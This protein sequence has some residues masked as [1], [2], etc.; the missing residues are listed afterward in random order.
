MNDVTKLWNGRRYFS[1]DSYLKSAFGE[2]LY[3]LSLNGGMSCPNRDGKISF[4]GCIF[5]SSGGSGD[6]AYDCSTN[7]DKQINAAKDLVK[8]KF[9]GKRYIAYFQAYTNTYA[10]VTYLEKLFRPVIMRDDIA[11]LS[12]ATR[13]DC[14]EDDKIQLLAEL[15]AI[16]PVWIELGLQTIHK[17][18]AELINRGYDTV[19]Y[20][21]AVKKLKAAGINVITHMIVGLPYE[22]CEDMIKT[23]EHIG[24]T[25][26]DGIKIQ[27][28]HVL[29]NT[30]LAE[31][32]RRGDFDVLSEDE[33][34][35]LVADIISVLPENIV[36]HRLTGDGNKK[37]LI[38]PKWSG[39]KRRVLN[40]INHELKV[41]NIIQGCS[42]K[43]K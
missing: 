43:G 35:H 41:R 1:L 10:P 9:D 26:S 31:M 28:L 22:S 13:P 27:L 21:N 29:E 39:D 19:C 34:I 16:K 14:L 32:Y 6:F 8:N 20:D 2:K 30:K 12:V 25:G 40:L 5:C 24:M 36:I 4:G 17:K 38:A 42:R 3:K 18:T 15:A 37:E 23:A 11:V 33:Y 7:T